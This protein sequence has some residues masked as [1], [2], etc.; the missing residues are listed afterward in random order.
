MSQ[1]KQI[2]NDADIS[3][4]NSGAGDEQHML[5]IG[6]VSELTGVNAVTLRAW[7]RRFGLVVPKRTPKGHR[8]YT[9]ENIAQI[10][11]INAWL[12]KGV[13]ISKVKPLLSSGDVI[14]IENLAIDHHYLAL[15]DEKVSND[16]SEYWAQALLSLMRCV[17]DFNSS[18]LNQTLDEILGLYPSHIV[19]EKLLLPWILQLE[20]LLAPRLDAE[21]LMAWLSNE[22][23]SRLWGRHQ[24]VPGGQV[25]V[26][27]MGLNGRSQTPNSNFTKRLYKLVLRMELSSL[28]VAVSD[29]A[30]QPINHLALLDGRLDVDA[31]LLIPNAK[32]VASEQA[33]LKSLLEPMNLPC[34]LIGHFAPTLSEL[35]AL[36]QVDVARLIE[37]LTLKKQ[38]QKA[39]LRQQ[40]YA[41]KNAN[42]STDEGKGE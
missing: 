33:E 34:Y 15:D 9:T 36:Q 24:N 41:L 26:A 19:K 22:I 37:E 11:E 32:H 17:S 28:K 18:K 6:E 27:L 8:L 23:L 39:L 7:Q 2:H 3:A 20:T 30:E 13:A 40:K 31:L 12:A 21:L 10:H 4:Q 25:K 35:P 38:Q 16:E 29:F 1:N 5:S 42:P 14:A